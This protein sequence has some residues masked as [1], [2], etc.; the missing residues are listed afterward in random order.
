MQITNIFFDFD[1][2]LLNS[3]N[4]H[5]R[6]FFKAL[7]NFN[8]YDE[9]FIY[10]PGE[11][12]LSLISEYLKSREI[13]D[14]KLVRNLVHEKQSIVRDDIEK[15]LPVYENQIDVLLK[16][17]MNYNLSIVSSSSYYLI[18]KFLKM[19]KLKDIFKYIVSIENTN[20][21]KP[22]PE[23]YLVGL[24]MNKAKIENTIA[25]EDSDA[26]II[27]AR[28]AGLEVIRFNPP[29]DSSTAVTDS[30]NINCNS[31]NEIYDAISQKG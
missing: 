19:Y 17:N 4:A 25:I 1:G 30:E 13:Y 15:S 23:P 31:Y 7:N 12:S 21:S 3:I 11:S 29:L 24:K 9:N 22:N 6:A 18:D 10:S 2:V 5:K 20:Y 26:G 27:S 28:Q 8:L 14:E 16:L